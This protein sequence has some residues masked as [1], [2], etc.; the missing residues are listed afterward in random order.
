MKGQLIVR[1]DADLKKRFQALSRREGK[2]MSEKVTGLIGEFVS[3]NDFSA[4][5][6]RVWGKIE[7]ELRE[8]GLGPEEVYKAVA[9]TRKSERR[10]PKK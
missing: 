2:S 1:I 7:G 5:V 10:P 8:K 9:E 3:S 4:R 6:D